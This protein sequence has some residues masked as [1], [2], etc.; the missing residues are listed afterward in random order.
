MQSLTN[1]VVIFCEEPS[2]N[3][4]IMIIH[5][6]EVVIVVICVDNDGNNADVQR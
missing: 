1:L 6:I 4:V 3:V 5:L 2:A